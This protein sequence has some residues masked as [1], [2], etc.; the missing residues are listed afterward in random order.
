MLL[1]VSGFF[2]GPEIDIDLRVMDALGVLVLLRPSRATTGAFDIGN[3]QDQLFGERAE[4]VGFNERYPRLSD[5]ID[6]CRPLV[7]AGEELSSNERHANGRHQNEGHA[8]SDDQL[9]SRQGNVV[10]FECEPLARPQHEA[11]ICV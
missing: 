6:G 9:R 11:V 8:D 1:G 4:P 7:E 5:R 10:A 3:G 2:L